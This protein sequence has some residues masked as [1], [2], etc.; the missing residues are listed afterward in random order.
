MVAGD[1]DGDGDDDVAAFYDYGRAAARLHVWLSNGRSLSYRG[2]AGWWRTRRGTYRLSNVAARMTVGDFNGD[3]K[4]DI[5]ASITS[6]REG[7]ASMSGCR[8]ALRSDIGT[9]GVLHADTG[10]PRWA[11]VW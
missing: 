5:A 7:H 10:C 1:F 11:T 4:D 3:G 8:P 6:G 2:N 9:G